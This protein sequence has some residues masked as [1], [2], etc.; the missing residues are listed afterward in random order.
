VKIAVNTRFLLPHR[1]EGIGWFTYEIFKR[2]VERHPEHEFI[3]YFDRPFPERF[4]FGK[5]VT[6]VHLPPPARHPILWRIWFD[7]SL[8]LSLKRRKPDV[9]VSTDGYL[10]LHYKGK[11]ISV[12][13][14][15]NFEHHPEYLK[16]IARKYFLTYFQRFA[17]TA[18]RIATVS[19]YSKH[20]IAETYS[21]APEKIDLVYNGIGHFFK[22]LPPEEQEKV[23]EQIC[24]GNPFFV[25][26][27]ALNPRKNIDGMLHAFARYKEMGGSRKFVVVG[28][29]MFWDDTLEQ[30]YQQHPY[31][32]DIIFT[33][34]LEREALNKVVASA[35]ALL[36]VS[37]FEGFGIPMIE[38]FQC[39][40]PV[41]T[42]TETSL[43]EVA[44]GAALLCSPHNYAEIAQAMFEVEKDSVREAMIEKGLQRAA[45]FSWDKSADMMWA[46]IEKCLQT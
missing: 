38:A 8:F 2:L 39:K 43:P 32:K 13:H 31:K 9:F 21:I 30:V 19:E 10:P 27:G 6:P 12:I 16:G 18:T 34:R 41:I 15:I 5:N 36:F 40:V 14:D 7:I 42:S 1:L 29:K 26:V 33:G 11:T 17:R 24:Q 3:F 45:F 23:R 44:D 25:F 28:S 37:H 35:T 22:P 46:S 4:V 20:D